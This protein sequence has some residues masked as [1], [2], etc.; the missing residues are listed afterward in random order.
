MLLS[1]EMVTWFVGR[2]LWFHLEIVQ[3]QLLWFIYRLARSFRSRQLESL[4]VRALT[5]SQIQLLHGLDRA[6][7]WAKL[8]LVAIETWVDS[9]TSGVLVV[10]VLH[11]RRFLALDQLVWLVGQWHLLWRLGVRLKNWR[12][13][14]W[15]KLWSGG[16]T[17][18]LLRL[19]GNWLLAVLNYWLV[20]QLASESTAL[21]IS[22]WPF[23]IELAHYA[24][25]TNFSR[26]LG[27]APHC[28]DHL[29]PSSLNISRF[30]SLQPCFNKSKK[31][32]LIN[33]TCSAA[34][35][36]CQIWNGN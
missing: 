33:C 36:S 30:L 21:S 16:L 4:T 18:W 12:R 8:L 29:Q 2:I 26:S 25:F 9:F 1:N 3:H 23:Q 14:E 15:L 11:G 17:L 22:K 5:S 28:W 10:G 24:V 7:S 19:A 31:L 35:A 34:F 20:R 32:V 27:V 13:L 6:K